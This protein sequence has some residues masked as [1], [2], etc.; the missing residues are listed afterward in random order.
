MT[1]S[2]MGW[3]RWMIFALP[4]IEELQPFALCKV[5]V[6]F[7]LFERAGKKRTALAHPNLNHLA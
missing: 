5:H 6:E 2:N 4:S 7:T 1:L 3:I